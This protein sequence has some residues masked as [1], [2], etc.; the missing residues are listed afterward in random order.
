MAGTDSE[1]GDDMGGDY[2]GHRKIVKA[3]FEPPL[4]V[5]ITLILGDSSS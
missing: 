1:A 4:M 3:I 5:G 2:A